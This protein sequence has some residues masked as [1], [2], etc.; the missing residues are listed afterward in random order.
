MRKALIA[1][2]AFA[3]ACGGS[4]GDDSSS[5]DPGLSGTW[6]GTTTVAFPG[7]APVYYSS[8]MVIAV[9][10]ETAVASAICPDGTGTITARGSGKSAEWAGSYLCPPVAF[11][12]CSAVSLTYQ[13]ATVTLNAS[14]T[15]TANGS[16]VANGCGVSSPVTLTFNG[17]N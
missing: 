2:L 6:T 14:G 4:E 8:Y 5:L 11:D 13:N 3:V 17:S 16:G 12:T 9:S 10:G 1:A 15:V 7:Y